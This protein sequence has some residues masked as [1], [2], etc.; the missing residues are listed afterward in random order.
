MKNGQDERIDQILVSLQ[1]FSGEQSCSEQTNTEMVQQAT[2]ERMNN[3]SEATNSVAA[4]IAQNAVTSL[5][6]LSQN[7]G[8]HMHNAQALPDTITARNNI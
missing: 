3:V 5:L 1:I 2:Q 7:Q 4:G 8:I 6:A